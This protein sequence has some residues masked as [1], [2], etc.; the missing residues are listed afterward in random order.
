MK[1]YS[2]FRWAKQMEEFKPYLRIRNVAAIS[3]ENKKYQRELVKPVRSK[4]V[5]IK[6]RKMKISQNPLEFIDVNR[7]DEFFD[8]TN[9]VGV[10]SNMRLPLQI[11]I[12]ES[13]SLA[14]KTA[15]SNFTDLS[16]K[17]IK[18]EPDSSDE[19]DVSH[20]NVLND[21][22]QDYKDFDA[23]ELLFLAYAKNVKNFPPQRQALIKLKMA[24]IFMEEELQL[25][26]GDTIVTN[27]S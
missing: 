8:V 3:T 19:I 26:C 5:R 14:Q 13:F 27:D 9:D 25:N 18:E 24:Q 16:K 15:K 12:D 17:K 1:S 23:T 22:P 2:K 21:L 6:E 4:S 20:Y 11:E 10:P 7:N